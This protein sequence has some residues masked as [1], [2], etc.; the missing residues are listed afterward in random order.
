MKKKKAAEFA[1]HE[2]HQQEGGN[3]GFCQEGGNSASEVSTADEEAIDAEDMVFNLSL[4]SQNNP[5]RMSM[6]TKAEGGA[7]LETRIV[8]ILSQID[9]TGLSCTKRLAAIGSIQS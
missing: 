1:D 2:D 5:A 7:I 6:S 8:V 9:S 3:R 4:E